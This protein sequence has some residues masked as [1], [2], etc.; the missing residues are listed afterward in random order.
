MFISKCKDIYMQCLAMIVLK[1]L[2]LLLNNQ[3][4]SISSEVC[5]R[6]FL[7]NQYCNKVNLPQ[8]PLQ[9]STFSVCA[10][11]YILV[12]CES[13]RKDILNIAGM[14]LYHTHFKINLN[15]W[16]IQDGA[17]QNKKKSNRNQFILVKL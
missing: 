15:A 1:L 5:I 16:L 14:L 12:K 8:F 2:E 10:N 6:I 7:Q 13:K 4:Q 17:D 9:K 11:Q 3:I